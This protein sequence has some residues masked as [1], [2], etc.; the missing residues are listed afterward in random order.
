[1]NSPPASRTFRPLHALLAAGC[2]LVSGHAPAA[3]PAPA[4]QKPLP[5]ALV[6]S[7][8]ALSGGPPAGYRA[9]HAKG[10][11]VSGTFTPAPTGASLSKAPHFRQKVPVVVRFSDTT[12]VPNMPDAS[13]DARPHGMAIRFQ[14]PGGLSTDIVGLSANGFPVATAEDF[15]ALLTAV[16]QRDGESTTDGTQVWPDDRRLV[17]LGTIALTAVSKDQVEDQKAL[18]FNPIDLPTGIAPSDD[19]VLAA[20]FPA[21]AVS[22]RQR[23][24]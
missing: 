15:V 18:L 19:P 22:V 12:G 21:Y 7:L 3:G 17:E 16:A 5:V 10:V 24:D 11:L 2:V 23:L 20:R 4:E 1:M 9:D 8:D 13:P 14:I 6:D